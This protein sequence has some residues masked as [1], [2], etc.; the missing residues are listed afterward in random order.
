MS[1]KQSWTS[2]L[3]KSNWLPQMALELWYALQK[4]T[5]TTH[6]TGFTLNKIN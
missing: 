2:M 4:S 1:R 6:M 5:S 3:Q